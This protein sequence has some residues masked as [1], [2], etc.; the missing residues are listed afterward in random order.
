MIYLDY[1]ATTPL[2][3]R[4]REEM[5]PFLTTHFGNPSSIHSAGSMAKAAIDIA[6]ERVSSFIGA[7]PSE[8]VFTSGGSESNNMAIKGV[9]LALKDKGKHLIT[10]AVEHSSCLESFNFL[11]SLGYE[12]TFIPVDKKGL[13]DLDFLKR[14]IK[15]KT[16]MIS[17]I[18]VNNETGVISPIEKIG[19]LAR[20]RG[21]VF[22]TDAV[23]AAGKIPIDV[24]RLP[25]DLMS[26]SSHKLYGPKGTG[27]LY[28][29]K[30][31]N[32][33][34]LIHGGSQERGNR[35]GTEN[36]AAIAG[37][38][39]ACS[40]M[41]EEMENEIKKI[42]SL[43]DKLFQGIKKLFPET[44]LNGAIEHMVSNTL[45][46]QFPRINGE[47]LVINL[48]IEGFAVST[49]SACSE[50][51]V[52]PS[53]V[54]LAM[55]RPKES[56]LSSVR[57]SLGRFTTEHEIEMLLDALSVIVERIRKAKSTVKID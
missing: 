46:I 18:Y 51:N 9:A 55:G 57:F 43:R 47:S 5:Q 34:P 41:K 56:A 15:D 26:F 3:E 33:V 44:Q 52:E 11:K 36:V 16:V 30:G 53:H 32:I 17:C 24:S 2:D 6:R 45:N 8:I 14:A 37:F 20:S 40:I 7:R 10:T 22:H 25:V 35:A 21:I 1:N 42:A 27:C 28:I 29:R 4:V 54:L 39:K 31:I 48:D 50:G 12:I 23:Q 13:P 49:G 38:G 19:Q